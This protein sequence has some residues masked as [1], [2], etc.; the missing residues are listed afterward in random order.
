MNDKVSVVIATY[1]RLK[2]LLNAI[3]SVRKQT[4]PNIEIIV[5]NDCSTEADYY[6]YDFGSDV[7]MINLPENTRIQ[8]GYPSAG[9]VRTVGMKEATGQ[10][11]AFLDD[12]DIWMPKKIEL[13]LEAMKRTGCRMS[14]TDGLIGTGIY[15]PDEIYKRFNK[16]YL[17][18]V[19]KQIYNSNG[20]V[21][22]NNGFPEIWDYNFIKINNCIICSSVLMEKSLLEEIN[23]MDYAKNGIEDYSCW[24][25]ALQYTN[26]VYVDDICFY[27][28]LA[29]GAG[30]N[31]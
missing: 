24:L 25:K 26:S 19:I 28:D 17:Y 18:E 2:Y 27:Y 21:A 6:T 12:D 11:I 23:Y 20:S 1:N 16:E 7:K 13:Q 14:S 29:H 3:E 22:V 4:Y 10:Y 30:Q 8:F 15:N 5:V 31:Y 9:Y